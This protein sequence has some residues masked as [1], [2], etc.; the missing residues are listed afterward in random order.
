MEYT[1]GQKDSVLAL[2]KLSVWMGWT[3]DQHYIKI[4]TIRKWKVILGEWAFVCLRDRVSLCNQ[5]WP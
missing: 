1:G 4:N 2:R 5:G 3:D